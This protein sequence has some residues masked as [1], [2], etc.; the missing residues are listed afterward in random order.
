MS[1][2]AT[3]SPICEIDQQYLAARGVSLTAALDAG[4]Y[5]A[6]EQLT[7][8]LLG[9]KHPVKGG[10]LAIPHLD[11]S[12]KL[13]TVRARLRASFGH[14]SKFL[15]PA[16]QPVHPYLPPAKVVDPALWKSSVPIVVV[17]GPVK[18]LSL[19][20]EGILAIGFGGVSAGGHNRE[21]WKRN[22]KADAHADIVERVELKNRKVTFVYDASRDSNPGVAFGE[23][24]SSAAFE[25]RGADVL[26]AALPRRAD[27]SDVGPDD[28]LVE[29]GLD[30]LE[31]ILAAAVPANPLKRIS[32]VAGLPDEE[33]SV[34]ARALLSDM[35]FIARL[36]VEPHHLPGVQEA[37]SK[38]GLRVKTELAKRVKAFSDQLKSKVSPK[39]TSR[40]SA[41]RPEILIST[42]EMEVVDEA[43]VALSADAEVYKRGNALVRVSTEG[44]GPKFLVRERGAPRVEV[45][46]SPTLE[47]RLSAQAEWQRMNDRGQLVPARPPTWAVNALA[48]RP[49]WPNIRP[50]VGVAE[51]PIFRPDGRVVWEPG[52]DPDTG[53]LL[54]PF[55]EIAEIPDQPT[56]ADALVAC[57]LLLDVVA[58][59]P[60]ASPE[61][62][63]AWLAALLTP[64]AMFAYSGCAPLVVIDANTR[65]S[66]KTLLVEVI[67]IIATGR[68]V[69]RMANTVDDSEMRKRLLGLALAGPQ[70]VLI[71]NIDGR[72]GTP[73]LDMALT[74]GSVSDRVLGLSKI[75]TVP[76][77][78]LWLGTGN[79]VQLVG[80][81]GRRVLP[82]R[83]ESP[84]EKPEERSGF[85]HPDLVGHVRRE[86]KHLVAAVL[87]ILRA[88]HLAGRPA[89]KARPWGSFE[90]WQA[91]VCGAISWLGLPEPS[92]A[93]VSLSSSDSEGGLVAALIAGWAELDPAGHGVTAAEAIR[94]LELEPMKFNILRDVISELV[95]TKS[96]SGP[97]A[98]ALGYALRKFKGRVVGNRKLELRTGHQSTA[99]WFVVTVG[100][101]D[102]VGGHGDHGGDAAEPPLPLR[103]KS[104][105]GLVLP[106]PSS[107]PPEAPPSPPSPP[108]LDGREEVPF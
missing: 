68:G 1:Y 86:R 88:F 13:V 69:P 90:G 87:T 76:L 33:R 36:Y 28:F 9:L 73:A 63:S 17:E 31:T 61:H 57:D 78:P 83:L 26:V 59:F 70:I 27:G 94:R 53:L 43:E 92:E 47:E 21:E 15:S 22:R 62:R 65:G 34:A 19:C 74:A 5:T 99:K 10:C 24:L 72:F 102:V 84:L 41:S 44:E 6:G 12:G 54:M 20:E 75:V 89:P 77:R 104:E 103:E 11:G 101:P 35:P 71:D 100:G 105:G 37:L 80:D 46:P 39:G 14:K 98:R 42:E 45:L 50:L 106:F 48:N 7:A 93:R 79:N 60:F 97:D 67:G 66:G 91:L 96:A 32:T 3:N 30:A 82:V 81:M 4:L 38:L 64:F 49:D 29:H 56:L 8:E 95:P 23:A 51:S 107:P 85:K 52:Y 2:D 18:C 58:D 108:L 55:G 16:G 25:A 40:P